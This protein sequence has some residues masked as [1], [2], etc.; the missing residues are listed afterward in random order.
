MHYQVANLCCM[1]HMEHLDMDIGLYVHGYWTCHHIHGSANKG[2]AKKTRLKRQLKYVGTPG[3]N[4]DLIIIGAI[5]LD[6][7][8]TTIRHMKLEPKC[9]QQL[10][11]T[12]VFEHRAE[13]PCKEHLPKKL[14][15]LMDLEHFYVPPKTDKRITTD[16]SYPSLVPARF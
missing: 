15:E 8:F 2:C 6:N 3:L 9:L 4:K 16:T 5:K 1:E 12:T 7:R 10:A 13:L 11:M 14:I